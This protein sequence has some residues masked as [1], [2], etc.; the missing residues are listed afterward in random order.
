ML[1]EN[2]VL[3]RYEKK[4][5]YKILEKEASYEDLTDSVKFL[6]ELLA[7]HHKKEV[8]ILIDEYDTPIHAAHSYG[9]YEETVSFV[10]SLFTASLKDNAVLKKGF[11]TGILRTAKEGIFW[12]LNNPD[13]FSLLSTQV[14]DK[15]GFTCED[16]D[17]LLQETN[18]GELSLKIK[19]WYNGYRCANTLL[20]NPWSLL[21]CV[22]KAGTLI[23]YWVNTSD[24]L[25]VKKL[26]AQAN[27]DSKN[28]I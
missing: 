20:Y 13:I 14:A 16:V 23:P 2:S 6:S 11:L 4:D 28:R 9:Y 3:E 1:E 18:L 12:G 7:R 24:N 26:I 22:D 17:T 10:R 15:F 21:N 19:S 27:S 8:I 25:L 5:F